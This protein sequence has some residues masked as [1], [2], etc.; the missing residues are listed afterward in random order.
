MKKI[1]IIL[2]AILI[3]CIL[4][5]LLIKY[6]GNETKKADIGRVESLIQEDK[7]ENIEI[8]D[9]IV[10]SE[11]Q[12]E[13]EVITNE[14]KE[15]N[16]LDEKQEQKNGGTKITTNTNT[17]I[18]SKKTTAKSSV[19]STKTTTNPNNNIENN[20]SITPKE[21]E[22]KIPE[23]K[24]KTQEQTISTKEPS[25]PEE[26]K[27]VETKPIREYKINKTYINKLRNTIIKEVT[28]NLYQLNKY[29]ITS[30]EQYKIVED[31]SIC[32]HNGGTRGGW[33]FENAMAYNTFKDSILRGV[34]MKIYAVDEYHNGEYIQTL[35]Y[36]GH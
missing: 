20:K 3:V 13:A 5:I 33:T 11:E 19:E 21:K 14:N 28:N 35:C 12:Q 32:L 10:N 36:Y 31:S 27:N 16:T 6:K 34:S 22:V 30:V 17:K 15:E 7:D 4:S 8:L 25:K 18:T 29:N 23:V 2:L 9:V 1:L 26:S 24:S